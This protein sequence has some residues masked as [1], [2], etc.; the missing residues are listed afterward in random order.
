MSK[1]LQG[2]DEEGIREMRH[3]SNMSLARV[4]DLQR[5]RMPLEV[6]MANFHTARLHV[7]FLADTEIGKAYGETGV[8]ASARSVLRKYEWL[9]RFRNGEILARV[10]LEQGLRAS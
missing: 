5:E 8:A 7:S 6:L 10:L 3:G 9:I 1:H 4:G 2:S